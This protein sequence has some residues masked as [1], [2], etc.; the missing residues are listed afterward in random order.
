MNNR[1]LIIVL[2]AAAL[3]ANG[4][5]T[6]SE[7]SDA[8]TIIAAPGVKAANIRA[9]IEFLADDLLEGREAGTRGHDIAAQYVASQ[10]KLMGLKPGGTEGYFQPIRF[11]TSRA[12]GEEASVTL[13]LSSGDIAL[14]YKDDFVVGAGYGKA[15]ESVTAD[16]VFAG[17][18]ITAPELD[19]DDYAGI[20]VKGKIVV[21]MG[22]APNTFPTDQRAF[23]SSGSGKA[24]LA[25]D[26]GAVAIVA[27]RTPEGEKRFPWSRLVLGAGAVK[28]FR[29]LN[30]A[31]EPH[32]G[33]TEFKGSALV[34]L[35]GSDKIFA[36]TGQTA[37][38]VFAKGEAGEVNSFDLGYAIS[39]KRASEQG[40]A[41]SSNVIGIV[42]GSDPDLKNEYVVFSAHVDH[43]GIRP[44]EGDDKLHNGAYDN[45]TG[46]AIM[47]ETARAI[48][49][50]PER[51][52]RSILFIGVTA[53]E[54]G[55]LGSEYF[56]KN[57]TV[58]V[59]SIIANINSDMPVMTFPIADV[60]VYGAEHSSIGPIVEAAA[61]AEGLVMTPDPSPEQV[62][63]IRSDQFSFIKEGIPAVYIDPGQTSSDPDI[64]GPAAIKDFRKNHYHRPSDDLNLPFD[65]ASAEKM[66]RIDFRVALELA[67][68]DARPTWNAGDFFGGKFGPDRMAKD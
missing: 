49:A 30:D 8:A 65:G 3:G 10:F 58:P 18:G 9:H 14:V 41:V 63:F 34:S 24:D 51:P 15:E 29:W 28:S 38:E 67:N 44:A 59:D 4:Q 56:A 60:I 17:F 52:R 53:E 54:K 62:I 42:E 68:A 57:P 6:A 16:A 46:T 55:L 21:I 61:M 19:Y 39:L 26:K 35:A 22:G 48:A 40:E 1:F 11:M 43:V 7:N 25:R 33:Y 13:R 23:Y 5:I 47:L 20:D 36:G 37:E 12:L 32:H 2:L 50:L 45:A 64:D 31:G 27:L 66:V